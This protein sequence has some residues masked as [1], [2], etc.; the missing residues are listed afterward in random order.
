LA[1]HDPPIDIPFVDVETGMV[2]RPWQ[3]WLIIN[4]RDKANR[5]ETATANNIALLDGDGHP[6]DSNV[7]I[8]AEEFVG[9]TEEQQLANK[10]FAELVGTKLLASNGTGGLSETDLFGWVS[11]TSGRLSISDDGDGTVTFTVPLKANFGITSDGDGLSLNQQVN[12][13]D[14]STSHAITDPADSPVDSDALR[15]DLVANTIPDVE[16]ALNALGIKINAI[17]ALLLASEIM[18]AP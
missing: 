5:Y 6:I 16:S 2:T 11:G 4:K 3:E 7:A 17:L 1:L 8:P 18:A 15:D 14:S 13:A 12:I 9:T 10:T